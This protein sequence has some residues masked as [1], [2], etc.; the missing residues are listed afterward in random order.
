MIVVRT[1][2]AAEQ[3]ALQPRLGRGG[4]GQLRPGVWCTGR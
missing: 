1:A 3:A 4:G 2:E